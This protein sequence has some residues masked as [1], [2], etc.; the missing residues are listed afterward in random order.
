M[1][2]QLCVSTLSSIYEILAR[3]VSVILT[4]ALREYP[5]APRA[6]RL[7]VPVLPPHQL[8]ARAAGVGD[9]AAERLALA[10]HVAVRDLLRLAA[11][12]GCWGEKEEEITFG[13]TEGRVREPSRTNL[14]NHV[15]V[16]LAVEGR[17][18]GRWTQAFRPLPHPLSPNPPSSRCLPSRMG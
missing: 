1:V 17:D 9:P 8:V 3:C 16:N 15:K 6:V 10:V 13:G 5:G 2:L 18:E 14:L 12:D 4:Q 7:A 11:P